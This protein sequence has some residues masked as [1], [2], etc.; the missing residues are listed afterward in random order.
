MLLPWT[1]LANFFVFSNLRGSC[2]RLAWK[3]KQG[4]KGRGRRIGGRVAAERE[5]CDVGRRTYLDSKLGLALL[6][7]G[8]EERIKGRLKVTEALGLDVGYKKWGGESFKSADG[9]E[10][11]GLAAI[12]LRKGYGNVSVPLLFLW[13]TFPFQ[14][15]FNDAPAYCLENT[16]CARFSKGLTYSSSSWISAA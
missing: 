7:E 12:S 15:P 1:L 14:R 10:R 5:H 6:I 3:R 13:C 8:L 4:N 16:V 9:Q 2:T 11:Q